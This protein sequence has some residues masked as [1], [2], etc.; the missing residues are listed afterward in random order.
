[1]MV[2]ALEDVALRLFEERGFAG[3]TVED[4]AREAQ[5]SV[6]TFYRYL[7]GK[8]DVLQVRLR[9]RAK[10]IQFALADRPSREP[11][12]QSVRIA[13]VAAAEAEDP[14]LVRRWIA[15][16]AEAPQLTRSVLGGIHLLIQPVIADFLRARLGL[17]SDSLTPTMLAAAVGGI[18]HAAHS[19]WF[20]RGGSLAE[21]ITEGLQLLE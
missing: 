4:I 8:D 11:P 17:P 13:S 9:R 21:T 14:V 6:R 12:L 7:S 3:V 10:I 1:M 2:S 18:V 19:E 16:V 20:R 15:V 5:V